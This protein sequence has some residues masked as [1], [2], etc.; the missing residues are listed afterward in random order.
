MLLMQLRGDF[1]EGGLHRRDVAP[2][3]VEYEDATVP[4][5]REAAQ[6]RNKHLAEKNRRQADG[7][8]ERDVMIAGAD[9]E[10]RQAQKLSGRRWVP[11]QFIQNRATYDGIGARRQMRSVLLGRGYGQDHHSPWR[12]VRDLAR[13]EIVPVTE[14]SR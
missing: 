1:R 9:G 4:L 7:P 6:L 13:R 8:A 5:L 12:K 3:R 14:R 11:M 2:V 10:R